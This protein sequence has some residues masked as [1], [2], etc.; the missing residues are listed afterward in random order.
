[1]ETF[2]VVV[3]GAGPGGYPAAIRAA[4][5]GAKTAIVEKEQLGGTC[6]NWGCI[7]TKTLIASS[8]LFSRMR[9]AESFG[10]G[11]KGASFDYAAMAKRK[12]DVVGKLR[13]GVGQ[14][15]KANGVTVL[16]GT[17]S[18][19]DARHVNVKAADGSE[20]RVEAKSIIIASGSE[21]AMP[22]FLPRHERVVESRAFLSRTTLPDRLVV[23]GGGVIGCEFACMAA[24][25]G[26]K[27]TVVEM[28]EDIL[29]VLDADIRRELRKQMETLGIRIMTG[30]AMEAITADS[31]KVSG[32]VGEEI[33]EGDVLL[34]SVG[35][36]PVTSGL[37][38]AAAG[39]TT[40]K[41]GH[42]EVDAGCRTKVA[43]I[44]A[45]GDVTG[46]SQ[47]AHAATS[48]GITAADNATG[49][50]QTKMESLVPACIFTSPEIGSVGLS[51]DDAKKKGLSVKIGKFALIGLGKALAAGEP[52]GFVKWV[53][54][55]ATDRLL[56]AH[57]IGAHA[58]EL[59]AEAATAIRAELTATELGNTIHCHPT[60]SESWMEAAHAVHGNCIHAAPKRKT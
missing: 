56:G 6:L 17:A 46:I 36:K 42:I 5:K 50:R 2:D 60:F 7:P 45:I 26:A 38:L 47:L 54:D 40:T 8:E 31:K 55:A 1:M 18:F 19:Q 49:K 58:T 15:L 39:L 48:Q 11:V 44:F 57:A 12:D 52:G 35:R 33:V 21:S 9:H 59:I 13:G 3:I 24:Q 53:V 29:I 34:V 37:N 10:L 51:E 28:L 23:L 14:L 16:T 4:Q 32:K 30:K 41:S 43:S 20:T 22:G 25:L 27:V